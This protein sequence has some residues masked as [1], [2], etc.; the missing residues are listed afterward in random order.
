MARGE[1]FLRG[2]IRIGTGNLARQAADDTTSSLTLVQPGG[3]NLAVPA[4]KTLGYRVIP[5]GQG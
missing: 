5:R 3:R 4:L 1:Q 2:G